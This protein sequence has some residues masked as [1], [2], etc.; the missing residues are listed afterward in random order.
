MRIERIDV[1]VTDLPQRLQRQVS[2][3]AYDTGAGG[4]LLGK[5]VLVRVEAEG[6]VGYGQIRPI[7]PGH[8]LPDTVHSVVGAIVD[9]YGPRLLG[10]R[11]SDIAGLWSEFDRVLPGNVNARAAIDHALHDALGKALGVPAYVILGGLCQTR[12]PLEWSVSMAPTREAMV[13]DARRA[14]VEHGMRVL[15]LKAGGRDGWRADVENFAAV[16]A[17]VGDDVVVG[18]D[19]NC[20][21]SVPDAVRAVRAMASYG[22]GYVEQP[23]ERR[24]LGGLRRV[25][26]AAEGIPVMADEGV[27][28]LADAHALVAA[29]AV[30][31][32]CVKLYKM[33][34]LHQA[35]KVA[36]V[37]EAAN[38][39]VNI[40]G[41]AVF[42]QLEAAAGAHFYAST[43]ERLVMPAAE[44]IFG[45]GILGPDPIA[46]AMDLRAS[47][48][49]V[50]PPSAPGLG[51]TIDEA[52]V[53]RHSLRHEVVRPL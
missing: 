24:D 45:L 35:K 41:L 47:G 32:F 52:A 37:A 2:S 27:I 48:G 26:N 30:D 9:I 21:W 1:Y 15:C 10:R 50:E 6:V 3:G 7:T 14:V 16:R 18:V 29:D 28:T 43:P 36:A 20:G 23:T 34:G 8:F 39:R 44:F 5:P 51:V 25:R 46:P 11:V 31:V 40:G 53:A 38:I 42:S 13:E 49:Y 33:G 19:P 12:I 22:L 17:A 4:T